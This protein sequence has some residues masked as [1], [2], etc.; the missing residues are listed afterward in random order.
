MTK[1]SKPHTTDLS[2]N[3]PIGF[4][5]KLLWGFWFFWVLYRILLFPF[6]ASHEG[7][8]VLFGVL[9]QV[10]MTLPALLFTPAVMKAQSPYA[11]IIAHLVMLLYFA[12]ASVFFVVYLYGQNQLLGWASGVEALMLLMINILLFMLLK[13]LPPMYKTAA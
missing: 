4:I 6:F 11:L 2:V 7:Q 10:I 8:E 13:R 5:V 12:S 1:T 9:W 3:K